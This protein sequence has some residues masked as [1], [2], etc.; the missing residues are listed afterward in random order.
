[1]KNPVLDEMALYRKVERHVHSW[2]EAL[3][4]QAGLIGAGLL[5]AVLASYG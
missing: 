3:R 1:M 2:H 5:T 4:W